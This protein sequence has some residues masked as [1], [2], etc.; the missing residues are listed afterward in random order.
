M[1]LVCPVFT[2]SCILYTS[3]AS[4]SKMSYLSHFAFVEIGFI[5]FAAHSIALLNR[6][7]GQQKQLRCN[8]YHYQ[9]V[10]RTFACYEDLGTK[11]IRTTICESIL[12]SIGE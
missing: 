12:A 2:C 9:A 10:N 6:C 5:Y 1:L 4:M 11:G 7:P 8:H 3:D